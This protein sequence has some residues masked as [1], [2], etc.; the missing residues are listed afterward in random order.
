M[1]IP[2]NIPPEEQKRWV[3]LL[4]MPVG[5]LT[6]QYTLDGLFDP[7]LGRGII[8][9]IPTGQILYRIE[10]DADLNMHFYH[11]T[12]GTKTRVATVNIKPLT[13][14]KGVFIA[15]TWSPEEI[16]LNVDGLGG[17]SNQLLSATGVPSKI[18]FRVD[19]TG[20][21]YQI[22]DS[23]VT[24]GEYSVFAGGKP[25]LQSTAIEAWNNTIEAV[26]ILHT[27]TSP[28]GY[29]F[30]VICTNLTIVMLVTG[31]E[32]YCKRRLL[33]V[34]Q[35]GI[36]PDVDALLDK[37]LFNKEKERGEAEII[38]VEAQTSSISPV[39]LLID[40]DR[41]GFQNYDRCKLA[42]NRAYGIKFGEMKGITS[43]L[44]EDIQRII[45]FRHRI[46]HISPMMGMLNQGS[47]PPEEPV[48]PKHEYAQKAINVFNDFINSLHSATLK[49][50]PK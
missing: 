42:Y 29:I 41:I 36:S 25:M 33:E 13:G 4:K 22:G 20:A 46:V 15:I 21:V 35:E 3:E 1:H 37:F 48:F 39:Q 8:L 32:T 5:T 7:K 30:E 47:V 26:K 17:N 16:S 45:G 49:L 23:G 19:S 28:Q 27:G 12:P 10:R 50:R 6:F 18:S 2:A 34:E 24:I 11:S 9:E 43:A 40:R 44:L 14:S 38:K 31:F